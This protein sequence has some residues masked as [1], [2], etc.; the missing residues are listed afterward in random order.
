MVDV[1]R[2]CRL[3]VNAGPSSATCSVC[4]ESGTIFQCTLTGGSVRNFH[5]RCLPTGALL[6]ATPHG[7]YYD[8]I[9]ALAQE[10]RSSNNDEASY[11]SALDE[12]LK[13]DCA[14]VART[15]ESSA[16]SPRE[17]GLFLDS[18]SQVAAQL[19]C[20]VCLD[21]V[22]YRPVSTGCHV[23]CQHCWLSWVLSTTSPTSRVTVTCPACRDPVRLSSL[24]RS[25]RLLQRLI[26]CL[27]VKCR[28]HLLGCR[29]TMTYG[30]DG[31]GLRSHLQSCPHSST[32]CSQCSWT[33]P[34]SQLGSHRCTPPQSACPNPNCPYVGLPASVAQHVTRCRYATFHCDTC[35]GDYI[36]FNATYHK[37]GDCVYKCVHCHRIIAESKRDAHQQNTNY[38]LC[39]NFHPCMNGC[40]QPVLRGVQDKHNDSCLEA[41]VDCG[42]CSATCKR[43]NFEKHWEKVH[44]DD[45]DESSSESEYEY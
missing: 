10:I 3:R 6:H 28:N 14:D 26:G 23:F 31:E 5:T 15:L 1:Y 42:S 40:G 11:L 37:R 38:R 8:H 36:R 18:Q 29:V 9:P 45:M 43:K 19:E 32:S 2:G 25:D 34:R 4:P 20:S 27:Q 13:R 21:K 16:A 33:G 17:I 30:M 41:N 39:S 22:A 35:K 7:C 44:Y 12:K 24:V